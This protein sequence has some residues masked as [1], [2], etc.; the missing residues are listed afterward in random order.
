[1]CWIHSP[2]TKT[3]HSI[4]QRR[5]VVSVDIVQATGAKLLSVTA[6]VRQL[7]LYGCG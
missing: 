1:M 3:A 2:Q 6:D 7:S 4:I 5:D